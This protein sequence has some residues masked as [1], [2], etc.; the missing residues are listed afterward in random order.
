MSKATET[1]T[2]QETALQSQAD[3]AYIRSLGMGAIDNMDASMIKMPR[4]KLVQNT[5]KKG[6]PGKWISNIDNDEVDSIAGAVLAISQSRVMFGEVGKGDK[7][8]CK[9]NDGI[10]KSSADG[11]GD[12]Y[13]AKCRYAQWGKGQGGASIKP[14]C[15]QGYSLLIAQPDAEMENWGPAI[16]TIKGSAMRPA[17]AFFTAMKARNLPSFAY[18]T[19]LGS[20]AEVTEKGRF[21]QTVFSM[22][23]DL[24]PIEIIKKIAETSSQYKDFV[25][26][27]LAA[28]VDSEVDDHGSGQGF[29]TPPEGD[30]P[31]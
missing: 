18:L 29:Y 20:K 1:A 30:L 17:K 7:P 2:A 6:T 4:Y 23:E 25:G 14:A 10:R 16:V 24:L 5:S 27:D 13:C 19:T 8:L 11:I 9:S 22:S 31:F 26:S 3:N 12:S 21:F 28:D 15:S